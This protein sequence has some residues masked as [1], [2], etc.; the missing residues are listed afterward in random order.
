MKN[1]IYYL[2]FICLFFLFFSCSENPIVTNIIAVSRINFFK[3]GKEVDFVSYI[4]GKFIKNPNYNKDLEEVLKHDLKV[5]ITPE[6]VDEFTIEINREIGHEVFKLPLILNEKY[7]CN[8]DIGANHPQ[9]EQF[10]VAV[11]N[12]GKEV[13]K[14]ELRIAYEKGNPWPNV[15]KVEFLNDKKQWEAY[16]PYKVVVNDSL[17]KPTA[18]SFELEFPVKFQ[19]NK[20]GSL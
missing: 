3:K 1:K 13:F 8:C 17:G 15:V 19:N 11:T 20:Q 18:F 4:D 14:K 6:K 7:V 16:K 9:K 5:V 2:S 10:K 12:Y